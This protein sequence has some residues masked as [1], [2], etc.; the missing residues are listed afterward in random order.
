MINIA[1]KCGNS[2]YL[3][4]EC[5]HN[6]ENEYSEEKKNLATFS[7]LSQIHTHVRHIMVG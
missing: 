4:S 6:R 1:F 7:N 5:L 3:E 2:I